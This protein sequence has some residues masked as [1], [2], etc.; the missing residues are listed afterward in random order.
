MTEITT[1]KG[2]AT[3][4]I[5]RLHQQQSKEIYQKFDF[6]PHRAQELTIDSYREHV[7]IFY[8]FLWFYLQKKNF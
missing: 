6:K 3:S 1:I 7:R 8:S 2:T 5:H 4:D